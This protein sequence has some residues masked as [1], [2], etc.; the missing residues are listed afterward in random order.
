MPGGPLFHELGEDA[1]LVGVDPF[2]GHLGEDAVALGPAF[3]EG[4]DLFGIGAAGRVVGGEGGFLAVVEVLEV[5]E[6]MDADFGVGRGRL[7]RRT[8]LA[9]DEL[10][11]V[12]DDR[13]RLHDV[14]EGLRVLHRQRQGARL[15]TFVELGDEKG[16]FGADRRLG[17]ERL[18]PELGDAFVHLYPPRRTSKPASRNEASIAAMRSSEGLSNFRNWD[19]WPILRA[20][21]RPPEW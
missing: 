2:L 18:L 3:P 6:G 12:E 16:P 5:L 11:V 21:S 1:G 7:G 20:L 10:A 14:L 8:A 15:R 17:R 13:L 19:S 4:D 9:D